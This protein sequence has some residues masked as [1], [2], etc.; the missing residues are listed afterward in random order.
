V[1]CNY[2]KPDAIFSLDLTKKHKNAD[3]F[4]RNA[5]FTYLFP[6]QAEAPSGHTTAA[7]Q[8]EVRAQ[9]RHLRLIHRPAAG[10][11]AP[12]PVAFPCR[13]EP[14]TRIMEG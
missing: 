6:N 13:L 8:D 14:T 4:S 12:A 10:R 2:G 5:F 3:S 7:M 9:I 11:T 1:H